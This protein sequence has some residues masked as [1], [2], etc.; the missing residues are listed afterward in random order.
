VRW[1]PRE[2]FWQSLAPYPAEE[3]LSFPLDRSR[4]EDIEI[5][6]PDFYQWP[7]ARNWVSDLA[8]G[9]KEFVPLQY[10]KIRQGLGVVNIQARYR[11]SVYALSIDYSDYLDR[12]DED[13]LRNC[14]LYF[15]MQYRATGYRVKASDAGKI[16]PGGYINGHSEMYHYLPHIRVAA[17]R[18]RNRYDVYGRFGLD[19]A[20][21]IRKKAVQLLK[22][23][24][25]FRYTGDVKKVRYSNFLMETAQSKICI[26]LP[27]NSDFCFRLVDYLA[28]GSC[29]IAPRHRTVMHVPLEDRK[30]IV[31]AKEDLSDFVS[32][33]SYYLQH[34]AEREQIRLD[35]KLYFDRY[36]HRTQLAAYYLHAFLTRM[37][38]NERRA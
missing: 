26:D 13:A 4:L 6:W 29:V 24:T 8:I 5:Q 12:I 31:Y 7:P 37:E 22:S 18:N 14:T 35:A 3:P 32:L 17:K 21:D 16:L 1:R 23:Q 15:K 19:F 27:S 33:C 34:D 38:Q 28:L 36:L 9:L 11:G 30:H 25:D 20:K 10:L 2:I